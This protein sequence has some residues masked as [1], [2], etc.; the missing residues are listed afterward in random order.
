MI[1]QCD[2]DHA[3]RPKCLRQAV[4]LWTSVNTQNRPYVIT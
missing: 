2:L 3:W 4:K 1:N